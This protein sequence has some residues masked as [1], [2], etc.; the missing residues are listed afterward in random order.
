MYSQLG[1]SAWLSSARAVLQII[2]CNVLRQ[3]GYYITPLGL[4][5]QVLEYFYD[6]VLT[7]FSRA[8]DC[9]S[10]IPAAVVWTPNLQTMCSI[11]NACSGARITTCQAWK[12]FQSLLSLQISIF[13]LHSCLAEAPWFAGV[14]PI[15]QAC[16]SYDVQ[17]GEVAHCITYLNTQLGVHMLYA[18]RPSIG[19]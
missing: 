7:H 3:A 17:A 6:I 2:A 14:C 4:W 12:K 13:W 18:A 19:T 8:S 10:I 16:T 1:A 11:C 15:W 5:S 9:M